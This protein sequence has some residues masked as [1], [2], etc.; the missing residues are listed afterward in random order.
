MLKKL[1]VPIIIVVLFAVLYFFVIK[2]Y[3]DRRLTKEKAFENFEIALKETNGEFTK[4]EISAKE[5]GAWKAYMY[6]VEGK[7]VKFYVFNND[8]K[9]YSLGLQNYYISSTKNDDDRLYGLFYKHCVIYAEEDF[10]NTDKLLGAFINNMSD[11]DDS[12]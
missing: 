10:P 11:Y 12:I 9:A 5:Y 4:K 3:G 8:S 7:N 1:I 2:P 6:T